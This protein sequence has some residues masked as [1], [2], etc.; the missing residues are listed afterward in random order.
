MQPAST[1]KKFDVSSK[2]KCLLWLFTGSTRMY[3]TPKVGHS[4]LA[5]TNSD[6]PCHCHLESGRL[7]ITLLPGRQD[8]GRNMAEDL[9]TLQQLGVTNAVCLAQQD[10]M[11]YSCTKCL[12]EECSKY[13]IQF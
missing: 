9:H 11:E 7:G 4:M 2:R 6:C 10:E 1:R 3:Y 5:L 12:P 13:G 8:R